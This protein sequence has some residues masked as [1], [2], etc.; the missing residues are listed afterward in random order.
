MGLLERFSRYVVQSYGGDG[1]AVSI[2]FEAI[3][4]PVEAQD[5]S[6]YAFS[7]LANVFPRPDS[8]VF[9]EASQA[10][11]A[12]YAMLLDSAEIGNG[13]E[14]AAFS[15]MKSNARANLLKSEMAPP[16]AVPIKYH[17]SSAVPEDWFTND[18]RWLT[19][20]P[21]GRKSAPGALIAQDGPARNDLQIRTAPATRHDARLSRAPLVVGIFS[22][23]GKSA[24][25]GATESGTDV[26]ARIS[27][28]RALALD[29][30]PSTTPAPSLSL[31]YALVRIERKWLDQALFT[32]FRNWHVP[33][34]TAGQVSSPPVGLAL[35][36]VA[37]IAVRELTLTA[38]WSAADAAQLASAVSVGPFALAGGTWS[39]NEGTLRNPR[40]Q[41]IGWLCTPV[42]TLPPQSDPSLGVR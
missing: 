1:S 25:P 4:H 26:V 27:G 28:T 22:A 34:M 24:A 33:G 12:L 14:S 29:A 7:R 17:L 38:A 20:P 15:K 32:F 35:L 8:D 41:I 5:V 37:A 18:N 11:D 23:P 19:Y 13:S 31:Q 9:V 10:L 3:G 39:P 40:T 42:P 6:D 30:T 21:A 2:K 36:P 16:S